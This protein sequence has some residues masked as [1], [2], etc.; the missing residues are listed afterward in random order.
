MKNPNCLYIC[1]CCLWLGLFEGGLVQADEAELIGHWQ[2]AADAKDVSGKGHHGE[3]HGAQ[4]AEEGA[5]FDGRKNYVEVNS[6]A[7]LDT[8]QGSFSI[9]AWVHTDA[10]LDDVLGDVLSK[11]D[12]KSRTG[13]ML[14]I[15]HNVGATNSQANYRHVQFGIDSGRVDQAW[16]DCGRPGEA[17]LIFSMAV[18][19]DQLFAGTCVAG[20]DQSGRV[21]RYDGGEKWIDCG[22][23]G[24]SN[25][26][27][28]LAV[29]DGKLYAGTAKYWLGG[30]ALAE[31]ENPNPGGAI[32]RYE[33]GQD[34][35][36]VG[37]LPE[38]EGVNGLVVY[39]GKLYASSMYAPAGFFRYEGGTQWTDCGVPDGRR[40]EQLSVYN[41]DL[42]ATTYDG[43]LIYRYNGE[44]WTNCGQL[45]DNTQTYAF[46]VNHGQLYAGT[47]PSG[48]VFRYV[49][50][51]DWE[52]VG[53][54]G[55]EKEVMGMAVY[56]GKMYG[57]TLPLAEVYRYDGGREWKNMGR[58]D[59]TPDVKYRRAWTMAVYRGKLFVGTLPS[60]KVQSLKAGEVVTLD[61]QLPSGWVH[62]AAVKGAD[63]L[64][65]YLNGKLVASSEKFDS[66]DYP[67][68]NQE[69]LKIGF[70]PHDYFNGRLGDVRFYR[71][72]LTDEGVAK[73]AAQ[74]KPGK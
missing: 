37:A 68:S 62:L 50:D 74:N 61:R 28:A 53:R 25:A 13:F 66:A 42:F 70:G 72:A 35:V 18:F 27:S 41:G 17:V 21:F 31:S 43:G 2:L 11:F 73:L 20:R 14:N 36:K 39:K 4:L 30:S 7:S 60:G 33:G 56:N 9:A 58:V 54:L 55:E 44:T 48:K 63:R 29:Y 45:G 32:Y 47:W 6:S 40:M 51:N 3:N 49:A 26:I 46:A 23:P 69:P 38:R 59:L 52:D 15:K 34:W 8:G 71:G 57:G 24:K 10:V 67:L 22:A 64:K 19:D 1:A 12:P 5:V 65:L 16:T